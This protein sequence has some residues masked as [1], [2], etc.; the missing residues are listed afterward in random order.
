[1]TSKYGIVSHD[2]RPSCPD[3]RLTAPPI[4]SFTTISKVV[5][6][7]PGE[8]CAGHGICRF[9][10]LH[11]NAGSH[12]PT[13][14][15]SAVAVL[16]YGG[17]DVLK[18]HFLLSSLSDCARARCFHNGFFQLPEPVDYRVGSS[19]I[20]LTLQKGTY[21]IM[22]EDAVYSIQVNVRVRIDDLRSRPP[23]G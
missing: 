11:S 21:L 2:N 9:E 4:V 20:S 16:Y 3:F 14:C 7:A 15:Q 23:E 13:G 1:M 6:G 22:P 10:E 5:F 19:G 18:L 12:K 17:G 8:H